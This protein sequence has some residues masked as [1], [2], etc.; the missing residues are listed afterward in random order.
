[1]RVDGLLPKGMPA[2]PMFEVCLVPGRR[3]RGA[4]RGVALD[5]GNERDPRE[6]WHGT[7]SGAHRG[8]DR[9]P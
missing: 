9:G 5:K 3:I 1:M 4:R 8:T 2:S 6:A 7:T